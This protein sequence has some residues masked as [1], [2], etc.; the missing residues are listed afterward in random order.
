MSSSRLWYSG[1]FGV[2]IALGCVALGCESDDGANPTYGLPPLGGDAASIDGGN[3]NATIDGAAGFDSGAG[4]RDGATMGVDG[5]A[6]DAAM[7]TVDA[8]V[9]TDGGGVIAPD[10]GQCL[11]GN[12]CDPLGTNTCG[13]DRACRVIQATITCE[14]LAGS[15]LVAGQGCQFTEQCAHGLV[16]INLGAGATCTKLCPAGSKGYCGPEAACSVELTGQPCLNICAALAKPCNIYDVSSC[17]AGLKCGLTRNPETQ[18]RYTGCIRAGMFQV[19]AFCSGDS[20][21]VAGTVCA[22]VGGVSRCQQVCGPNN[23]NPVCL[24]AGQ[25]CSGKTTQYDV[26]FCK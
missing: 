14:S 16:C 7:A 3:G 11:S 17:G 5:A 18:E 4:N 22:S 8:A 20:Q 13:P 26:S 6:R 2:F 25:T 9:T 21:C 1:F 15:P 10:A 24:V 23:T 12:S 19:G